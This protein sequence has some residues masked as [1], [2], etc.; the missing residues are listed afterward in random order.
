MAE[1]SWQSLLSRSSLSAWGA[2]AAG[3]VATTAGCL[4]T[5]T[6]IGP[7]FGLKIKYPGLEANGDKSGERGG[8]LVWPLALVAVVGAAGL[9][10]GPNGV[11]AGT[12]AL[13]ANDPGT[14]APN[15]NDGGAGREAPN[16]VAGTEKV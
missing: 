2:A 4:G 14:E 6:S 1:N 16:G 12:E 11:G 15:A 8:V 13:N 3:V 10:S 5:G 9:G 7:S